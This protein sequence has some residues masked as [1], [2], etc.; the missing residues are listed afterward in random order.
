MAV[1]TKELPDIHQI[2]V[3]GQRVLDGLPDELKKEHFGKPIVI[4][5]DSG[6][7]F[8]G[9]T[10]IEA[11]KKARAKYPDKIFFQGRLGYKAGYTFKGRR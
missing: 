1:R 3:K 11:T 4:E 10:P 5:V 8:I 6:E 2:S 9:D 7:Y